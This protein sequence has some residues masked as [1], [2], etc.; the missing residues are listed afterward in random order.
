MHNQRVY[1]V[2][3]GMAPGWPSVCT[4]ISAFCLLLDD[5]GL[6]KALPLACLAEIKLSKCTKQKPSSA[7]RC[8]L[9]GD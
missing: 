5:A 7:S 4:K 6:I 9:G 3:D 1:A 8:E 2:E